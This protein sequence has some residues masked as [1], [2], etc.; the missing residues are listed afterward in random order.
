MDLLTFVPYL[1]FQMLRRN[2]YSKWYLQSLSLRLFLNR[3][4]H[5]LI[6]FNFVSLLKSFTSF[7]GHYS[8]RGLKGSCYI[9]TLCEVINKH[10]RNMDLLKML[11][12][13]SRKVAFEFEVA[14]NSSFLNETKQMPTFSSTLT[15]DL[16]FL[17]KNKL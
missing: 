10:W 5:C 11:T 6:F 9:Q 1:R 16:Y 7:A 17:P 8:F 4:K 12:I 14:H 15:R 2:L 3:G 13:I